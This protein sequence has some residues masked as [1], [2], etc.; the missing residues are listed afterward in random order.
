MLRR[1][2][3]HLKEVAISVVPHR[4]GPS[5]GRTQH[6]TEEPSRLSAR[7]EDA[8]TRIQGGGFVTR[9][10]LER[11]LDDLRTAPE[12]RPEALLVD[13]TGVAGYE[14]AC[15]RPAHQ[16]LLDADRLG[17][18]RIAVVAPSAVMRTATRLAAPALGVELRTFESEPGA[19]RWLDEPTLPAP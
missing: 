1:N 8:L 6:Y 11:A 16:F 2:A 13:L 5:S 18:T 3:L 14:A 9:E 4:A 12:G 7:R 15:L 17:V 10:M 19:A